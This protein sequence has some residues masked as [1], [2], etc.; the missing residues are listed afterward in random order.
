MSSRKYYKKIEEEY[1]VERID[2]IKFVD[3]QE[4]AYVKWE[5]YDSD[6]NT[7]EPMENLSNDGVVDMVKECREKIAKLH[8]KPKKLSHLRGSD[9]R[10]KVDD[11]DYHVFGSDQE[12]QSTGEGVLEGS[13]IIVTDHPPNQEKLNTLRSKDKPTMSKLLPRDGRFELGDKPDKILG[14]V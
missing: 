4:M 7:W 3:G 5:N 14:V 11:E 10:Q 12:N 2:D 8:R 13:S 1:T 6:E 9:K